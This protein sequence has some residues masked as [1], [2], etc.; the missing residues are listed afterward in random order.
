MSKTVSK[1][2]NKEEK[3]SLTPIFLIVIGVLI[4]AAVV[5]VL[6]LLNKKAESDEIGNHGLKLD[7]EQGVVIYDEG[8]YQNK[9]DE[10]FERAEEGMTAVQYVPVAISSDGINFSCSIKNS[11]QN[12]Y[13]MYISIYT[14]STA[15][16]QVLLTGL[17]PPGSGLDHFKSEIPFQNGDHEVIMVLTKVE[18][19]HQS[20][21][22]QV[23]VSLTLSVGEYDE[24]E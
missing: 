8:D 12:K 16:E 17:I 22:G 11:L 2:E 10:M 18:D 4:I 20:I 1:R 7:Y 13:D 9:V 21:N 19:D 24:V 14:D 5:L 15:S 23:S 6:V 3:K